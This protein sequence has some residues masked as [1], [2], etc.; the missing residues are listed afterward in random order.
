MNRLKIF[1]GST[2]F[3]TNPYSQLMWS[4]YADYHKGFCV[5]YDIN[6]S[7]IRYKHLYENLFPVIYSKVRSTLPYKILE[8]NYFV[9]TEEYLWHIY[10]CGALRKSIDWVWQDEW[11][12]LLALQKEVNIDFFP[13]S[14]VFLGNKMSTVNK[15]KIIDIC[16]NRKI[17]YIGIKR[18]DLSFDLK[19]CNIK[20]EDCS[21]YKE[22]ISNTVF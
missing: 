2:C 3:T 10:A 18:D 22:K 1:F 19:D 9:L 7:H 11:R 13:I 15:K 14:K 20:C 8:D 6:Q 17:N 12:L 16:N 4:T 21:D 5:E